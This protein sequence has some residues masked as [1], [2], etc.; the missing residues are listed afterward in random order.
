[1][2][3]TIRREKFDE[4]MSNVWS[5]WWTTSAASCSRGQMSSCLSCESS[6]TRCSRH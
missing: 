5:A 3:D 4:S 1:M 2:G 6:W